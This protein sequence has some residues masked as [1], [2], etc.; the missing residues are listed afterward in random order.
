MSEKHKH[1][2]DALSSL[3]VQVE[4]L[5]ISEVQ[6]VESASLG[7]P[8][9]LEE[10]AVP[11]PNPVPNPE[12]DDRG[13]KH[14]SLRPCPQLQPHPEVPIPDHRGPGRGEMLHSV[15]RVSFEPRAS[16]LSI[17]APTLTP[18]DELQHTNSSRPTLRKSRAQQ[19]PVLG[20]SAMSRDSSV[21]A[22]PPDFRSS[23]SMHLS[24]RQKQLAEALKV[25]GKRSSLFGEGPLFIRPYFEKDFLTMALDS[26]MG[27]VIVLNCA[28]IG[29]SSD[30]WTDW[31]GWIVVDALFAAIFVT[32]VFIQVHLN[33]LRE[34][35]L[36]QDRKWHLFELSLVVLALLEVI[37]NLINPSM[38]KNTSTSNFSLFRILRLVRITRLFRV[39]RLAIFSELVVMVK[40]TLGGI[41]TL[42]WSVVLISLPL[43][44]V[45][46]LFR[47][48]LGRVEIPAPAT[49]GIATGPPVDLH[50]AEAFRSV[51]L[52]LFTIFRCVVVGE[53]TDMDGRPIFS[54]VVDEYGWGY[55]LVYCVVEVFM[56]F[57]L[58]NVIVAIFVENVLAGA[59]TNDQ[60]TRRQRL[61]DQVFWGTKMLELST[62]IYDTKI[63][64]DGKQ[65]P[66]AITP[67]QLLVEA[68]ELQIT[69]ELFETLRQNDQFSKILTDLDVCE[70][71]WQHLF[72]TLDADCSGSIDMDELLNGIEFLRGDA[73][74]GDVVSVNLKISN[75]ASQFQ[76]NF[77]KIH[78]RLTEQEDCLQKLISEQ[79]DLLTRID[80]LPPEKTCTVSLRA[81]RTRCTSLLTM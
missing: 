43:Y 64:M 15:S 9:S 39:C 75:M 18:L 59:K 42:L 35:L 13:R 58:F 63:G 23:E 51:G 40:G 65:R 4:H 33:G 77:S 76:F 62:L 46:L 37:I 73:R 74:R 8:P 26:I 3:L 2:R 34:Y 36:G 81:L 56:T 67:Q 61:R 1:F 47:E 55:G 79:S 48:T 38:S 52:S 11:P 70:E 7:L 21:S 80:E 53:C 16:T 78:S 29:I 44:A 49:N 45:S 54:L 17:P 57:G 66:S 60:L 68:L 27:L 72:D 32:E 6:R 71:D 50:G 14:L 20:G 5:V 12:T 10:Y 28:S 31:S 19:G 25:S 24:K 69:P 30:M 41:K 22:I